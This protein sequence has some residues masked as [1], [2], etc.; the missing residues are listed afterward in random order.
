[1]CI[2]VIHITVATLS[3]KRTEICK[4]TN[5]HTWNKKKIPFDWDFWNIFVVLYALTDAMLNQMIQ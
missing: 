3:L 2:A 4:N 5:A 1:M